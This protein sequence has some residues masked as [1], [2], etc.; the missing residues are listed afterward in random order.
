VKIALIRHL[1]DDPQGGARLIAWLARDLRELGEDVTLYCYAYDQDR[2]FPDVLADV[3]VRFVRRVNGATLNG[4]GAEAGWRRA[5]AQVRRYFLEA[6]ALAALLDPG[7]EVINPHEWLGH[8]SAALFGLRRDVPIVWTYNDPSNWHLHSGW[9]PRRL[10]YRALGWFDTRQVNRFTTVATLSQWM[11]EVAQRSFTAPV[12]VVRCGVDV[13]GI[14]PVQHANGATPLCLLSV[15]VLAPWRR[16]EDGIHAVALA[17]QQGV[18]CHYEVIGSDRFWPSYATQLR[19]LAAT[20]GVTDAVT[21]RFESVPDS[22]LEAAFERADIAL[23]P[24]ESQA[25]GLAQLEAM[26]RGIPAII[27]RGAGVSEVLEDGATALLVDVRRPDQ[28]AT[29]IA[30]L[31]SGAFRRE[32]G[33][34]GR[35]FVLQSCTSMDYARR[36]QGVFRRAV[37]ERAR[38]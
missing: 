22:E 36:M 37:A 12:E 31:A 30:R 16:F 17:R 29:A 35:E 11:A 8:R 13:R 5:A 4:N 19:Q 24:N 14:A 15:G 38:A 21:L 34:R 27:S 25:W 32:L 23:F 33:S 18:S 3:P 6:P 26:V 7:T 9:T 20:L 10:P 2:C 28:I 1:M